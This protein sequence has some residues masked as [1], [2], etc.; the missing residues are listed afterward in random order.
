MLYLLAD[1]HRREALLIDPVREQLGRDVELLEQLELRLVAALETH[2]H[3]D[4]VTAAGLLR[5]RLDCR[6][7]V[8]AAAGVASAATSTAPS[9]CRWRSSR[10]P[11]A[12][13]TARSR[14]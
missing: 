1:E 6:L 4:H 5:E 11:R 7:G 2:V 13:G 8:A 12:A 10:R 14:W 9:W 3:A